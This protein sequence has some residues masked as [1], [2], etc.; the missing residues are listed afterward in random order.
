MERREYKGAEN[1][2]KR[3]TREA[4]QERRGEEK[5]RETES[6]KKGKENKMNKGVKCDQSTIPDFFPPLS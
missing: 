1:K 6:T 5:G 2:G 4:Q 3:G